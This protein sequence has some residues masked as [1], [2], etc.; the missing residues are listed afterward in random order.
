[1]KVCGLADYNRTTLQL[2]I[3]VLE[4]INQLLKEF[5]LCEID[6]EY[7][8]GSVPHSL[9]SSIKDKLSHINESISILYRDYPLLLGGNKLEPSQYDIKTTTTISKTKFRFLWQIII[10]SNNDSEICI[11]LLKSIEATSN[12][13][14]IISMIIILNE[15]IE[16]QTLTD[17]SVIY[18]TKTMDQLTLDNFKSVTLNIILLNGE[19]QTRREIFEILKII[20]ITKKPL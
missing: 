19:L 1:M 16:K 11:Q 4:K 12:K 17:K 5:P 9:T 13:I 3:N 18:F 6:I 20:S 7:T 2:S 15:L 10:Y 8:F 14:K